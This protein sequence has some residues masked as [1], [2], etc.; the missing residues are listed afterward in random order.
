MGYWFDSDHQFGVE[1]GAFALESDTQAF[2]AA[3]N[4][5]QILARPYFDVTAGA[6]ASVL[7]A[8]PGV[9]T[10][11]V[12]VAD[13]GRDFFGLNADFT[14][15]IMAKPECR[16]DGLIGYQGLHTTNGWGSSKPSSRRPARSRPARRCSRATISPR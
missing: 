14:A 16:I 5:A 15:N 2:G 1:C 7:V 4:G 6:Q 11:S 10:G 12:A 3:S 9:S 13:S 8:F